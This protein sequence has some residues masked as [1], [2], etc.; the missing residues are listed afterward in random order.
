PLSRPVSTMT[1][2]PLRIL[3]MASSENF[4]SQR[5]DLHELLG[6]QF[7]RH[8]SKDAGADRLQLCIQQHCCVAVEFDERAI[9]TA[10]TLR[11]TDHHCAIDLAF[12]DAAARSSFLDAHLNDVANTRIAT[13]RATQHLDAKDGLGA[14]VV[15]NL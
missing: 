8:G 4:R 6:T 1:S 2:S 11:R 14:G 13:L 3:F 12:F 5:H 9:A 7:T 10:N 15:G